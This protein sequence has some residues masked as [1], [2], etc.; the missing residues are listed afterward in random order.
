ML[1][2]LF[3][4]ALRKINVNGGGVRGE[5]SKRDRDGLCDGQM[6]TKIKKKQPK[7]GRL[8]ICHRRVGKQAIIIGYSL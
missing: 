3:S 5:G 6:E 1:Q 2:T 8:I 4:L 7:T